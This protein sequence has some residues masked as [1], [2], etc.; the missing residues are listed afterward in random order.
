MVFDQSLVLEFFKKLEENLQEIN[1]IERELQTNPIKDKVI[2][3]I[4]PRRAGK[5]YYLLDKKIKHDAIYID[6][7]SIEFKRVDATEVLKI[8]KLYENYFEK[9]LDLVLLDEVPVIQ[10][11]EAVVRSLLNLGYKVY[12][13]GS[14]SKL[15][16]KEIAT[17]LRGR[18]LSYLLLPFSFREFLKAREFKF[19][20]TYS[21]SDTITIKNFLN[22][23][24]CIGGFPEIV[25]KNEKEKI[26]KEY[27]DLAFFKDFLERH[28][29]KNI[30][31]AE[32]IFE[33]VL[34]NYSKEISISKIQRFL[35]NTL[36]IKTRVTIY[37]YLDKLNDTMFFF[38]LER[39]NPSIYKR[40]SFPRKVY[41]C[42]PSIGKFFQKS[43]NLGPL[44]ENIVFLELLRKTN[45]RP[46]MEIYYYKDNSY[47]IDFLIKKGPEVKEL[48]QVSYAFDWDEIAPREY[49]SLVKASELF[50]GAKLTIITWDYE[51]QK[52]LS[53]FGKEA[54]IEFKPLWKWL[55]KV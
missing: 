47:E 48:I 25:L 52:R 37:D 14:S 50:K 41:L 35:E 46:L 5:T 33:Y 19:K 12:I 21:Y 49:E 30:R 31:T 53:W 13:S 26:L 55:L 39:Y 3:I 38:L 45:E 9:K 32:T 24:M 16:S 4:G 20:K 7:E 36:G 6:F 8:I 34:Q 40:K 11:W 10:D 23:Y 29:I 17:A 1:I 28:E 44:M 2:S 43:E 51:D 15:L 18:S 27:L 54:K 42:D 22:E